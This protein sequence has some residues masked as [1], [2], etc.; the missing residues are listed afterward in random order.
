MLKR[1]DLR[2]ANEKERQAAEQEA[3]LLSRLKHPNIVAYK[4]SFNTADGFLCIT[5]G[6]CEGGDLYHRLQQQNGIPLEDRQVIEWFVQISMAIKVCVFSI[7]I[8]ICLG[9]PGL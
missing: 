9:F 8:W 4:E 5:M 7:G 6:F 2:C 1:V 3:Q